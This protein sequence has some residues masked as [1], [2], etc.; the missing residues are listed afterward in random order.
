VSSEHVKSSK[1][2]GILK[3]TFQTMK[4]MQLQGDIKQQGGQFV[5]GPGMF[6]V[7]TVIKHIDTYRDNQFCYL[8]LKPT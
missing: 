7:Y 6:M 3:S 1:L 5:L 2:G 4:S 8:M